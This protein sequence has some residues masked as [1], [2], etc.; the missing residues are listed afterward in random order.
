MEQK[1]DISGMTG[2]EKLQYF[3]DYYLIKTLVVIAAAVFVFITV[4]DIIRPEQEYALQIAVYDA[5]L[6]DRE[7]QD[8]SAM[9]QSVLNTDLPVELDDT[10]HADNDRDLLRIVSLSESRKL[11]AV[12]A[13]R[14]TLEWLAGYGYFKDLEQTCDETFLAKNR[15]NLLFMHGLAVSDDGLLKEGAEGS[16]EVYAAGFS[17]AGTDLGMHL[18]ALPD[19]AV[20][21]I[22][23]SEH[24]PEIQRLLDNGKGGTDNE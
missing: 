1:P 21:V 4:R 11:D 19:A 20:G 18:S 22:A 3:L 5:A 15:E 8:I 16:G 14:K 23:E 2:D 12:I 24:L 13:G 9:V 6:T 10:Y 17:L 7:K